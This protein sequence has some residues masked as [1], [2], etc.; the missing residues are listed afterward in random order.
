MDKW[1]YR[2]NRVMDLW[3]YFQLVVVIIHKEVPEGKST[4]GCQLYS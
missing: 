2:K 3:Q 1:F 4:N